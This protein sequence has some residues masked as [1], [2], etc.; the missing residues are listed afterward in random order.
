M[1][2]IIITIV[3]ILIVIG[4]Y[5]FI[6]D[7]QIKQELSKVEES[8]EV[9]GDTKTNAKE[10][11]ST[12]TLNK[13]NGIWTISQTGEYTVN[14][15]SLK[16]TFTG[17]KPGG[18]HVGTFNSIKS[19]IALDKDGIPV[20]VNMTIDISSVKT[21]TEAVDKHLQTADFFDAVANPT[22]T[23]NVKSI[24]ME[25]ETSA[26]AITDITM[27]GVTKT[28]SM[29]VTFVKEATGTKF[30]IDTRVNIADFGIAYGPVL[31]EVRI[32]AEGVVS[33]K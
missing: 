21:D 6:K 17:Y 7:R 30:M 5:L 28:I 11:A 31:N 23:V 25:S 3:A 32:S 24:Q 18:Q 16:F 27:K 29:P 19:E 12:V 2:K 13:T 15:A 8:Q 10:V 1:R 22:I 20:N 14:P 4:G 9:Q 33:K 26:K